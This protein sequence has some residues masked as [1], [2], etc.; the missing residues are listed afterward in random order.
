MNRRFLIGLLAFCL[1]YADLGFSN[2]HADTGAQLFEKLTCISCHG[3]DGVGMVRTETKESYRL[4]GDEFKQLLKEG[5]PRETLVKMK[6]VYKNKYDSQDDF[7]AELKPI[8]SETEYSKYIDLML[9]V[10]GKVYYRKGDLIKGFEN[11]PKLAGNK[12]IYLFNQMKDI[13]EGRRTNGNSDAMRG[14]QSYLVSNKITDKE[15][16][17]IAHYLSKIVRKP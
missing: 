4:A 3:P 13:L 17:L 2:L 9:E 7:T 8:L 1:V 15:F 10:G 12:E 14:I 5:V 6:P 16:R 11:Y